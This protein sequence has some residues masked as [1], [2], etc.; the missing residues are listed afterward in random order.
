MI[1]DQCARAYRENKYGTPPIFILL[2]GSE[3]LTNRVRLVQ[4][5]LGAPPKKKAPIGHF[6]IHPELEDWQKSEES[7]RRPIWLWIRNG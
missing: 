2:A 4:S 5:R 1:Q 6:D 3:E 7:W